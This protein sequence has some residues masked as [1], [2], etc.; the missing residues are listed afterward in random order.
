MIELL[1]NG[2][3]YQADVAPDAN[4]LWVIREHLKLVG[5]KYGCGEGACGSCTVHLDG[6][7]ARSCQLTVK[8]VQGKAITTIE[9]IPEDHPVKEAWIA[10]QTSQCGYC[11]PGQIMQAIAL[12]AKNPK[13]TDGQIVEAMD[14]LLCRCGTYPRIIR[15]IRKA[16]DRGGSR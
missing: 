6:E 10:E 7:P 5:T 13:P 12:L 8:D 3:K 14:G 4:L 16:A 15:A 9:G 2:K 11:Q 1:V